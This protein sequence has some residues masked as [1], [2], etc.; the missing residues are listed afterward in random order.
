ME[1]VNASASGDFHNAGN[2]PNRATN[3]A[4]AAGNVNSNGLAEPVSS[5]FQQN[6]METSRSINGDPAMAKQDEG[7]YSSC[8]SN[9]HSGNHD[10]SLATVISSMGSVSL[11][12]SEANS[13]EEAAQLV[14]TLR[15]ENDELKGLLS[16]NLIAIL[17]S[18]SA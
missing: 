13:L 8:R 9:Q 2:P 11:T 15:K 12:P 17:Y 3:S 16:Q 4:P 6:S 7:P 5:Y 14:A 10:V 1:Q 18:I